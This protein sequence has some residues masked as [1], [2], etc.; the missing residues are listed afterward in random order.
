MVMA[1]ISTNKVPSVIVKQNFWQFGKDSF[2]V[3]C[4]IPYFD[5]HSISKRITAL[6]YLIAMLLA[7]PA[8]MVFLNIIK[9]TYR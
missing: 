5:L 3:R 9:W 7:L 8:S 4:F 1:N 6:A 2:D